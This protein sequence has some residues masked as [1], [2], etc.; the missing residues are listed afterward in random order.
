MK[1]KF[2]AHGAERKKLA[3]AVGEIIRQPVVYT[4]TPTFAFE[5][6]AYRIDK[7]GSLTGDAVQALLD[8]LAD[9]GFVNPESGQA[10]ILDTPA[11]PEED[12]TH[13]FEETESDDADA[14][15]IHDNAFNSATPISYAREAELYDATIAES[16]G[17]YFDPYLDCLVDEIISVADVMEDAELANETKIA[18]P[19]TAANPNEY[20]PDVLEKTDTPLVIEMPLD[21]F[22]EEAIG[23]LEKMIA[24]KAALIK[25][26]I[27]SDALPIERTETTLKF[28][29]FRLGAEPEA[30]TAYS[31][32]ISA[33]CA[34]AK[35]QKRVTAKEKP[36]E[37]ER[38]AFRVFLIRLGFVGDE[39]KTARK[40]LLANLSGNSAFK[41]GAP[42]RAQAAADE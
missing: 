19:S 18:P 41:N 20:E 8:A 35:A 4:G 13:T 15:A 42:P 23:N 1:F 5:V 28:P 16:M 36:V 40:I 25:K 9:K 30:A 17:T 37:N 39:Y 26:A 24:S 27:G 33:L 12:E 3:A 14:E 38:F 29:W 34:A 31:L 10:F 11:A 6:G 2:N 32:L 21:G 7:F 22:T